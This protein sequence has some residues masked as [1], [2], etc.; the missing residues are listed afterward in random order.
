MQRYTCKRRGI[1]GLR[2]I[3]WLAWTLG[4]MRPWVES[5]ARDC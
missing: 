5:S 3:Q 1:E 2:G 4:P